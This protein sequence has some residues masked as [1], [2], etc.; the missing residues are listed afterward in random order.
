M[1]ACIGLGLLR[2][3]RR[4]LCKAYPHNNHTIVWGDYRL[5]AVHEWLSTCQQTSEANKMWLKAWMINID[6]LHFAWVVDD[7]TCILVT[8]LCVCPLS[9]CLSVLRRIPALLHGRG[10]NMGNGRG[11]PLVVHYWADL[12]SVHRFRCHDN[13][14]PTRNV[15]KRLY[16]PYA[17][18]IYLNISCKGTGNLGL[19]AGKTNC[20]AHIHVRQ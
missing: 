13:I 3:E 14:A 19:H 15:S 7:A 2:V 20:S 12:R 16:S 8:R 1:T 17:W 9:V 10:C 18:S 6:L 11:C 4:S 5:V